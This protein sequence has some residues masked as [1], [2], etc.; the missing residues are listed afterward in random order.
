MRL[1]SLVFIY[2][3]VTG[4]VLLGLQRHQLVVITDT[5]TGL[6]P[7]LL[8]VTIRELSLFR[9]LP[10]L[11]LVSEQLL[12][13]VPDCPGSS[14]LVLQRALL[15]VSRAQPQSYPG[16]EGGPAGV[17]EEQGEQPAGAGRPHCARAEL[18]VTLPGP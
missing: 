14:R 8:L 16:H 17:E 7:G 3:V 15:E 2:E 4:Q 13:H 12:L 11:P 18:S 9:R 6:G 10:G 1:L 5:N